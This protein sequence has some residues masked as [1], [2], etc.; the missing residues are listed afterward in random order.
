[1]RDLIAATV[2]NI[3][4]VLL[5]PVTLVGYVLWI[6]KTYLAGRT[7]GV[8]GT[9]QGPLSARWFEHNL[10]TRKKLFSCDQIFP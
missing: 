3:L 4:S 7:S 10:G 6:G 2:F 5:F 9:A 1:M 8:S